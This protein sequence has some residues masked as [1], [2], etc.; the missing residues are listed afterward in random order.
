MTPSQPQILSRHACLPQYEGQAWWSGVGVTR[1]WKDRRM[2]VGSGS[3]CY[4]CGRSIGLNWVES[5]A[6]LPPIRGPDFLAALL[7][8]YYVARPP[9]IY[10]APL[11]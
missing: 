10:S 5:G 8:N 6:K 7:T 9:L 1:E 2:V 3:G 11:S 4:Y